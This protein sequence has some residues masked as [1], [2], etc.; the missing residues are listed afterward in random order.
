MERSLE[1]NAAGFSLL[2][3]ALAMTVDRRWLAL[4]A[5]V[6]AFLL[7]LA[8]RGWCPPV[9]VV[10]RL[11]VRTAGE[12]EQERY[13]LRALRG[14]FDRLSGTGASGALARARST[15]ESMRAN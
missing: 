14:D 10:R 4:P 13:A 2:G 9:P 1:V 12:I 6:A 11:G 8:V 5:G 15:L 3:L 7:Q